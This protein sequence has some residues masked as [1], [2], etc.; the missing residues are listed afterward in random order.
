MNEPANLYANIA[1]LRKG[2]AIKDLMTRAGITRSVYYG[3]F[4]G[5]DPQLSSVIG[6]ADALGVSL[7]KL[8]RWRDPDIDDALPGWSQLTDSQ[9]DSIANLV[10]E[11]LHAGGIELRRPKGPT[12]PAER[13][14]TEQIAD[15]ADAAGDLESDA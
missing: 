15:E 11:Y 8:A 14:A 2:E 12:T 10:L 3:I 13:R 5:A 7:D 9:R 4:H 1:R 6:I